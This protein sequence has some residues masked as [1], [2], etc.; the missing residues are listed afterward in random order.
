MFLTKKTTSMLFF[1]PKKIKNYV[2]DKDNTCLHVA[3]GL[4]PYSLICPFN[5]DLCIC[6]DKINGD[7]IVNIVESIIN[8][9]F[10]NNY[11]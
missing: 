3:D 7:P 5:I 2:N 1:S 9:D 10:F 8:F 4:P 11:F 6:F